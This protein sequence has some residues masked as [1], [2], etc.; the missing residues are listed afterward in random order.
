MEKRIFPISDFQRHAS[1]IVE[2]CVERFLTPKLSLPRTDVF[3]V[4]VHGKDVYAH[5]VAIIVYAR[6]EIVARLEVFVEDKRPKCN[7]FVT[8]PFRKGRDA[9]QDLVW[10]MILFEDIVNSIDVQID[11]NREFVTPKD[12]GQQQDLWRRLRG[13]QRR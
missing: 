3:K 5:E 12:G 1:P 4:L 9:I 6:G 11:A 8:E 7:A 13:D 2:K 10:T